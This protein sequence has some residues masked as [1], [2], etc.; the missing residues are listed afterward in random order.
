M[1]VTVETKTMEEPETKRLQ[2]C[3]TAIGARGLPQ[4]S[5]TSPSCPIQRQ[6]TMIITSKE[7]PNLRSARQHSRANSK[8]YYPEAG[9]SP[10]LASR[11]WTDLPQPTS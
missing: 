3:T 5:C 1:S 8:Q 4:R 9:A 6:A 2:L 7:T 11:A 10:H